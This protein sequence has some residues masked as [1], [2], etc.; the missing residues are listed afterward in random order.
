MTE[1]T[2]FQFKK[3]GLLTTIQDQ[4]RLGFQ[5]F[6]V[7]LGG[8]MDLDSAQ[9][10]NHLVGNQQNNPLL[11]ITLHGPEILV[12]GAAIIALTG[13]NLTPKINGRK[14]RMYQ[15]IKVKSGDCIT[16]GK[17]KNGCR[18]YLAIAGK[19]KLKRWLNSTSAASQNGETLT[20]DSLI[21]KGRQLVVISNLDIEEKCYPK[22]LQPKFY[23]LIRVEVTKG[24]EYEKFKP[25][26]L[27]QFF[28]QVH[29]ISQQ[30]NRMG[31]RLTES[32]V[33]FAPNQEIISSGI[34]PGT[35]Q[36][37]NAGQPIILMKDAQT[38]GGYWRIGNVIAKDLNKLAQLKPG[39]KVWFSLRDV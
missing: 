12:K 29:Q 11:E 8:A 22:S 27:N 31:Y 10:A 1:S 9:L 32:L 4:P 17:V 33:G 34:I 35:I 16:F 38:T 21:K 24:P 18:T 37:T 39:D 23:D 36:I 26:I 15:T 28:G 25:K 3:A 7:P 5:Q 13:A 14:L 19:W 20:P 6:G 30:S 2:I